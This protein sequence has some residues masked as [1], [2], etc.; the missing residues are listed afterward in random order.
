MNHPRLLL[1]L[2]GLAA[3]GAAQA[4]DLRS[5]RG[6]TDAAARLAY[7]DA[8]PLPTAAPAAT[9]ATVAPA[10]T[11]P[12]AA[13]ATA[14]AAVP[15]LGPAPGAPPADA[16]EAGFGL[17]GPA[18]GE[19]AALRSSV[20]GRFEGWGPRSRIRLANGQVWEV[21][22]DSTAATWLADPK[23]VVR[24]AALGSFLLE[25]VGL[26]RTARVKRVE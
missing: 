5:C 23:V 10:A 17:L 6:M 4:Q 18:R 11:V 26:N 2:T 13:P 25:V 20:A 12:P 1:L 24:R 9:A 15:A 16:G 21:T 14:R 3:A 8:L 7:Y 22:D 19:V